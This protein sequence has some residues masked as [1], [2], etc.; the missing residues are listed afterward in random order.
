MPLFQFPKDEVLTPYSVAPGFRGRAF[1]ISAA[2]AATLPLSG[3]ARGV[4]FAADNLQD[5]F[6]VFQMNPKAEGPTILESS[7]VAAAGPRSPIT[8]GGPLRSL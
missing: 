5:Q 3:K 6:V 1:G 8:P 7:Q 4:S 2:K